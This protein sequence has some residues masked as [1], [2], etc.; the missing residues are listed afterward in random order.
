MNQPDSKAKTSA[1]MGP[2]ATGLAI[3]ASLILLLAY[4]FP[5]WTIDLFAP[6]YPEGLQLSIWIH[7]VAGDL[8]NVNLLNHYVGM[9]V[10]SPASITELTLMPKV[11]AAIIATM[12]GRKFGSILS[13]LA[14]TCTSWR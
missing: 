6:Q 12:S 14:T 9:K 8:E 5:L 13:T 1:K 11:L 2:A 3:A 4:A 7:K 10:I